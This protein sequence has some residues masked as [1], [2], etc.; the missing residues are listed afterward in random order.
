MA[1]AKATRSRAGAGGD[2]GGWA[3]AGRPGVKAAARV[4]RMAA[5][6]ARARPT[7]DRPRGAEDAEEDAR[8][9]GRR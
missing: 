9:D 6:L 2:T 4:R 5:A 8:E 7:A 3:A 1:G